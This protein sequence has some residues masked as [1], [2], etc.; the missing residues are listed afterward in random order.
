M[1][2]RN[3]RNLTAGAGNGFSLIEMILCLALIMFLVLGAA[4]MLIYAITVDR[5]CRDRHEAVGLAV[6]RL[7]RLKSLPFDCPELRP[8]EESEILTGP[9]GMIKFDLTVTI[10]EDGPDLKVLTV[11]AAPRTRP[12]RDVRLSVIISRDLGF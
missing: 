4:Q 10:E 11:H 7:E 8:G 6:G 12:E 5:N 3:R 2:M 9:R 1:T